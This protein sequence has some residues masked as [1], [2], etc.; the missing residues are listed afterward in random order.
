MKAGST[1]RVGLFLCGYTLGSSAQVPNSALLL[2]ENGYEVDIFI[3]QARRKELITFDTEHI[4]V[5]DLDEEVHTGTGKL[6]PRLQMLSQT[7]RTVISGRKEYT[8][9]PQHAFDRTKAIIASKRYDCFIGIEAQGL[10]FAGMMGEVFQTPVM[11]YSLELYLSDHPQFSGSRFQTRKNLERK[12]HQRSIATIIQDEERAELLC[13]DN[14]VVNAETYF[15]PVS[16][17]GK[18]VMSKT[19]W[20]QDNLGITNDKKVILQF[21]RIHA[22][23]LSPEVVRE[24][25]EFPDDWVAVMHGS[26]SE[27]EITQLQRYN[28]KNKVLFSRDLIPINEVTNLVASADI[29]LVFYLGDHPNT[30]LTGFSS[31]KLA[32]Y[33]KC[34]LPVITNDFPSFKRIIEKQRCGVCVSGPHELIPAIRT[35]L[36]SYDSFRE[37]AFRCYEEHYEF[38]KHFSRVIERIDSLLEAN[39]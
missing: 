3:Y 23:R 37:N 33:L 36:S 32:Y 20:L 17:L 26:A 10:I 24:A 16:L 14:Q 25:Q 15:V 22:H 30:C 21:G 13:Q 2:A 5:Y 12:Y 7:V 35:I 18:P 34:G 6:R 27:A 8:V 38:S 31:E 28:M 4:R 9:I 1:K 19:N 39:T 11:Y 29:G